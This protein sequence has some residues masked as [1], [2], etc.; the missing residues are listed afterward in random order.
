VTVVVGIPVPGTIGSP[1][2]VTRPAAPTERSVRVCPT[3]LFRRWFTARQHL[4]LSL[5]QLT[6]CGLCQNMHGSLPADGDG[7]LASVAVTTM[8]P[9]V[10]PLPGP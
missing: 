5:A 1:E 6:P 2:A 3:T 7:H 8:L 9:K 10:D 4:G